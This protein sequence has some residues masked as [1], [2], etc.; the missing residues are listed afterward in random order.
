MP[1]KRLIFFAHDFT[2]PLADYGT[3]DVV[4]VSPAFVTGV[5]RRVNVDALD[6]A[7]VVRQQRL[8]RH[9]IVALHDEVA[10]AGVAR[11]KIRHVLEQMKRDVAVMIYHRVFSNPVERRHKRDNYL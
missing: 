10:A 11:G 4:V 2:K 8:E 3:V 7:G 5:V 9:Q 1:V 6:L